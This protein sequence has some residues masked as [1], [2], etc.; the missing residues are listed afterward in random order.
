MYVYTLYRAWRNFNI[1]LAQHFSQYNEFPAENHN[2]NGSSLPIAVALTLF[3]WHKQCAKI[4]TFLCV[5]YT[6]TAFDLLFLLLLVHRMHFVI[7]I[8]FNA[9]WSD[10][11]KFQF[12]VAIQ[13][14]KKKCPKQTNGVMNN[15]KIVE[16]ISTKNQVNHTRC[17]FWFPTKPYQ[18]RGGWESIAISIRLS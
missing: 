7:W 1:L 10:Y 6:Q 4:R 8:L 5:L 3:Y 18:W 11:D 15:N 12:G 17:I 9:H 14:K 13:K 16:F 2:L